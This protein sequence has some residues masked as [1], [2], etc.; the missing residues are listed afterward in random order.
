MYLPVFLATG[1]IWLYTVVRFVMA[2]PLPLAARA[3]LAA[4]FLLIAQYYFI[5]HWIFGSFGAADLPRWQLIA[6]GWAFGTLLLLAVLLLV[7][8]LAGLALL[9]ISRPAGGSWLKSRPIAMW[10]GVLAVVL[11]SFGTWSGLR[12]PDVKRVQIELPKLPQAF[13]G[14]RM[15]QLTDLHAHGLLPAAWQ[16]AVVHKV[17]ALEPDV[18]VITGDF[19]D[20]PVEL[21]RPDV[22][23]LGSLQARDGV[24]AAPGNHEYYSGYASWMQIFRELGLNMLV[25]DHVLLE[26][27]GAQLAIA[28]VPDRQARSYGQ[29]LPDLVATARQLPAGV[30]AIL[31]SHRPDNARQAAAAGFAL[32]L[33]GHTHGGQILGLHMLTKWSNKGFVSGLYRVGDMQLYVSNGTGL[34]NGL[35]LRLGRS[36][37]ITEIT[38]RRT[39]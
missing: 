32:G 33:S 6:I 5:F 12:V 17:N 16:Q 37:E 25:N 36:S 15:V 28:G 34:W 30:P 10:V 2:L 19:L 24:L 3:V 26:R 7:R 38:L 13:D 1:L 14:Y 21:R 29:P 22:E 11:G 27:N 18:I 20:G 39:G 23:P 31:L 4:L 35:V 9:A 8:D